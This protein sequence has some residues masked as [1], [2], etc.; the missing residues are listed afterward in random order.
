VHG[1]HHA[2]GF[3][4]RLALRSG[5]Q[6]LFSERLRGESKRPGHA[7]LSSSRLSWL[8]RI[9]GKKAYSTKTATTSAAKPRL[10]TALGQRTDAASGSSGDATPRTASGRHPKR[11]QAMHQ[12]P[13]GLRTDLQRHRDLFQAQRRGLLKRG[14]GAAFQGRPLDRIR[15]H[16]REQHSRHA[17]T[18]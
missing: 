6:F 18:I 7:R 1:F 9:A 11:F 17:F 14:Q 2:P 15:P 8:E 3:T 12:Q 10:M 13:G 4:L 5:H 16:G